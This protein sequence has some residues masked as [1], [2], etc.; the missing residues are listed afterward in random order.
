MKLESPAFE[1]NN[2]MPS[3]YTCDGENISP[4][5]K[6]TGEP[7]DVK[8]YALVVDDPDALS[9]LWIH[10]VVWNISPDFHWTPE[11]VI[12]LE[13]IEGETNY[14]RPGYGGPCPPTGAHRYHFRIF[15]LNKMLELKEKSTK[16][17]LEEAMKGSILDE[18]LLIG[19]Y[20]RKY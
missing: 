7:K 2:Y 17:D 12:P 1:N 18:G 6:I 9:G 19:L 10:W 15:A 20:K 4:P 11:G 3:K 13:G 5:L 16:N 8:S 14:G